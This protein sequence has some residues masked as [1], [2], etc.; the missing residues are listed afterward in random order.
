MMYA[1]QTTPQT[2]P[3]SRA[4]ILP[5][6]GMADRATVLIWRRPRLFLALL[7]ALPLAWL[8]AIYLGSLLVLLWQSF[9]AIDEFSG[10]VVQEFTLK[11]YAELLRPANYDV[12]LRT[13][14]MSAAVTLISAIIAWRLTK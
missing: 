5:A 11:T 1:P 3:H 9:Y 6:R 2:S 13:I 12:I 8:G 10:M 14:L 7:L 4:A